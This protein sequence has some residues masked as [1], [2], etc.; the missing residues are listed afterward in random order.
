M[1][2]IKEF[3]TP[4]LGLHPTETGVTA[5]AAAAR[6]IGAEYNEAGSSIAAGGQAIAHAGKIAG[7]M[8]VEY[9]D[10]KE[11]SAGATHGVGLLSNLDDDWNKTRSSITDPNTPGVAEKWKEETLEPALDQFKQGFTTQ[12]SQEWAEQFTSHLRNHFYTKTSADMASL[13]GQAVESNVRQITNQ[14]GNAARNDPTSLDTVLKTYE[15]AVDGLVSSPGL[16]AAEAGKVKFRLMQHGSEEIV[17]SAALG[18]IEKTG[19]IPDWASK[20]EYSKYI[21]PGELKQFQI[22]AANYK[23]LNDSQSKA[24]VAARSR[25]TRDKFD[26]DVNDLVL[27]TTDDEGKITVGPQHFQALKDIVRN[28]PDGAA[29]RAGAVRSVENQLR[30]LTNR[31]NRA[32][33]PAKESRQVYMNL[34]QQIA[35]G[36]ITD[37][38]QIYEHAEKLTVSDLNRLRNEQRTMKTDAGQTLL[39]S[40]ERFFKQW[41][42]VFDPDPIYRTPAGIDRES[43]ARMA[44]EQKEQ[45]LRQAG[46]NPQG[47]YNPSSPDYFGKA[48]NMLQ[49]A[50]PTQQ[51]RMR[52]LANEQKNRVRPSVVPAEKAAPPPSPQSGPGLKQPAFDE[53][54]KGAFTPPN[55]WQFSP[56]RQ[57]YRDP[58][59]NLYDTDG[60]KLGKK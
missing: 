15:M 51:Q 19:E 1:P 57:Q 38:N 26:R 4:A 12:K 20:E 25:A 11:K 46:K 44:A 32:D 3:N 47:A 50:Q 21:T 9:L 36:T 18:H 35:D 10:H 60:K 54:F 48:E 39:Q 56:S 29:Q 23:R 40:R 41:I 33:P 34:T 28:N 5:T 37:V 59:G 8:Y 58:D 17:K 14:A 55:N 22:A 7:D 30:T 16:K 53:R 42:S 45:E 13:A 52:D 6:R 2:Q 49:Y 27:S 24:A 31:M 43:R